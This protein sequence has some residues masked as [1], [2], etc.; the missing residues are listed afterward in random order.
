[1][2]TDPRKLDEITFGGSVFFTASGFQYFLYFAHGNFVENGEKCSSSTDQ[3]QKLPKNAH[4]RST[5]R[6]KH[7]KQ[8]VARVFSSKI[9]KNSIS[10]ASDERKMGKIVLRGIPKGRNS[11]KQ[12]FGMP[13]RV[14]FLKNEPPGHPEASKSRKI[15]FRGAPKP[16]NLEK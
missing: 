8:S 15:S 13:R 3:T 14:V 16:R 9:A 4:R 11:E 1:M 5:K 2:W 6:E 7:R 12:C 10:L